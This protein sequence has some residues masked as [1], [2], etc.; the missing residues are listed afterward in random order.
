MH[1]FMTQYGPRYDWDAYDQGLLLGAFYYSYPVASIPI[2][3]ALDRYGI[4]RSFILSAFVVSALA[5]LL[6]PLAASTG[7]IWWLFGVRLVIG[8]TQGGTFPN[9]HRLISKWAPPAE[10]GKFGVAILGSNVGTIIAWAM[11]GPLI[12]QCGWQWAFYAVGACVMVFLMLWWWNVYDR[13]AEHPRITPDERDF[14][15]MNKPLSTL[16]NV[17]VNMCLD[18]VEYPQFLI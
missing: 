18:M 10:L 5:V 1:I 6:S 7:S 4:G 13:P 2:G 9:I 12:A 3:F 11:V 15:E 17:S 8:V 14:I 16:E